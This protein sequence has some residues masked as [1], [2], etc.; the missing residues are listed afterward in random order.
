MSDSTKH[1]LRWFPW[2]AGGLLGYAVL[3]LWG[4]FWSPLGAT[5]AHAFGWLPSWTPRHLL[6]DLV[7][8]G[9]GL[10]IWRRADDPRLRRAWGF[11]SA[12]MAALVCADVLAAQA[13]L[14]W[15]G[16]VW[17]SAAVDVCVLAVYVLAFAF[18]Y[19]YPTPPMTRP[20]RAR[21]H[22]DVSV[23]IA[24]SGMTLW[25]MA[26]APVWHMLPP[27]GPLDQLYALFLLGDLI[28]LWRALVLYFAHTQ[29]APRPDLLLLVIAMACSGIGDTTTTLSARLSLYR[30]GDWLSLVWVLGATAMAG[31]ALFQYRRLLAP[32][33]AAPPQPPAYNEIRSVILMFV[34][35]LTAY[36]ALSVMELNSLADTHLWAIVIGAGLIV[37]LVCGRLALT[38]LDN[39]RLTRDLRRANAELTGRVREQAQLAAT[40]AQSEERYRTIFELVSDYAYSIQIAPDGNHVFEWVTPSFR[41]VVGYHPDDLGLTEACDK[42]ILPEDQPIITQRARALARGQEVTNEYRIIRP[43][44]AIRWHRDTSRPIKDVRTDQ[45]VRVIGAAHDI[46][47]RKLVEETLRDSESKLRGLVE[48][49]TD[50]IILCDEQGRI[51]EWNQAQAA[52]TGI[53]RDQALGR[54]L[55]EVVERLQVDGDP[56][57]HRGQAMQESLAALLAGQ[58]GGMAQLERDTVI[59]HP[60][61]RRRTVHVVPFPIQTGRGVALGVISRDV[62]ERTDARRALE[63]QEALYHAMFNGNHAIKLLVEPATGAIV[64]ANP[65]ACEFYGF[66]QAELVARTL[67]DLRNDLCGAQYD[68][69]TEQQT[70]YTCQHRQATGAV[71]DV[72]VYSSPITVQGKPLRFAII[73]DIT[74]R[75]RL[76]TALA[77]SEARF[78][79]LAE[80]A[81][82]VVYRARLAPEL[83]F[84]YISPAVVKIAGY[85]P[86]DFYLDPLLAL[87]IAHPDDR[88]RFQGLM[89]GQTPPDEPIELR[90]IHKD[91]TIIWTEQRTT[92]FYDAA[93]RLIGLE[94]I[95]RNIS[96]RKQAE[97]E[98]R[99]ALAQEHELSE[100]RSRFINMTSHE[101][102]TPLST[103]LTASELLERYANNWT[104][105]N[106]CSDRCIA[107]IDVIHETAPNWRY[108]HKRLPAVGTVS[109]RSVPQF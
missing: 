36:A 57:V 41:N 82:D 1:H 62:T 55:T 38:L 18:L 88:A 3:W 42:I 96:E 76:T 61:G 58:A 52:I 48:Q 67:A 49:S 21:L 8:G 84:D 74:E 16:A 5:L 19:S 33:A 26:I 2:L 44:G 102:R 32:P 7:A 69:L 103:I 11:L 60:D 35:I 9:L 50:G 91:G 34:A 29:A 85:T 97:A 17:N 37:G 106:R 81:P 47:E 70:Y 23:V 78:R 63:E 75:Q 14:P 93:G 86:A 4:Y 46:T 28:L 94:G 20:A 6:P 79:R 101:F 107:R 100:L 95:A 66:S 27:L 43:D 22:L 10:L 99:R 13:R 104:L 59:R 108:E 73:H 83:G 105:D 40:L 98:I 89:T 64:A 53:A 72:E 80:N 68:E 56:Q 15:P 71:R 109:A 12:G 65:A 24:V 87:K 92:P 45:I 39:T 77:D 31:A 25:V 90:W 30:T 54:A 51:V